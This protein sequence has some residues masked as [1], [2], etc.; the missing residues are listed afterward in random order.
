MKN[1]DSAQEVQMCDS[2]KAFLDM[3]NVFGKMRLLPTSFE[4][5][6]LINF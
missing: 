4:N 2:M 6:G 3:A 1:S 5:Y